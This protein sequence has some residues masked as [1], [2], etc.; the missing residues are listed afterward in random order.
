MPLSMLPRRGAEAALTIG[1]KK[2]VDI[3]VTRGAARTITIDVKGVAKRYD[4]PADIRVPEHNRHFL[5][6]VCF[7]G[8]LRD[9]MLVPSVWVIPARK[10]APFIRKYTTRTVI[11]RAA[12]R[13][14]G[15]RFRD[16][17]ASRPGPR[18]CS[19]GSRNPVAASAS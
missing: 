11:S 10:L 9:P 3:A 6:L 7:E 17:Q 4:W 18:A 8:R 1:N 5:A 2:A 16:P 19:P 12:V 13:D 14:Q 15:G